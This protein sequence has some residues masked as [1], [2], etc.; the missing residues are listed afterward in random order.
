MTAAAASRGRGRAFGSGPRRAVLAGAIVL[1]VVL[2]FVAL[3]SGHGSATAS[4]HTTASSRA[5]A[6]PHARYG[7]LPS[8]LPKATVPVGRIVHASPAHSVLGIEGDTVAVTLSSG[9]VY[10]T[11]VGPSVPESG[12]FPVPRT[13]PCTFVVTFSKSSGA[14]PINPAD[15]TITDELGR[16]HHPKVTALAGGA[17]LSRTTPGKTVSLSVY[18]VL[19]TGSGSLSWAPEGPRPIVSW[20]F[21]VEID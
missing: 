8:W 12:K 5:T 18:A 6:S 4:S 19:P 13:S 14:I 16:V 20:D 21:D 9:D 11:A 17:P 7:G 1:A 15:F 2:G 3:T 10:A